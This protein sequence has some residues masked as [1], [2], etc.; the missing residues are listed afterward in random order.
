MGKKRKIE[1]YNEMIGWP[2]ILSIVIFTLVSIYTTAVG[3]MLVWSGDSF[4]D[5]LIPIS[6]SM[7]IGLFLM[8]LTFLVASRDHKT[9]FRKIVVA[10]CLVATV[11]IFFNFNCIYSKLAAP[12]LEKHTVKQLENDLMKL[13]HD[14]NIYFR[15][16]FKIDLLDNEKKKLEIESDKVNRTYFRKTFRNG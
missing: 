12:S 3:L 10:Y 7:A 11:S 15:E 2:L 1:K 9:S 14:A 6:F 16:H 8:Y 4:F 13:K 5:K